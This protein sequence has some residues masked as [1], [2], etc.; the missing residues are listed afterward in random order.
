LSKKKNGLEKK[1]QLAGGEV[2]G[3]EGMDLDRKTNL[4]IN[5]IDEK[6][7]CKRGEKSND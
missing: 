2:W 7:W 5:L 4:K 3:E 1:K 6:T